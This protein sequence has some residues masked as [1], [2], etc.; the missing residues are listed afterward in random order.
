MRLLLAHLKPYKAAVA[1]TLALATVNQLLLLVEPQLLRLM[2]DRYVM[3]AASRTPQQ[4]SRGVA[5]LV[6]GGVMVALIARVR[7]GRS[8][9]RD[10]ARAERRHRCRRRLQPA[11][12]RLKP[13]ATLEPAATLGV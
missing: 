1:M 11:H 12:G 2:V 6:A 10:V 4:S 8:V 7:L 5:G 9:R 13:A 3:R